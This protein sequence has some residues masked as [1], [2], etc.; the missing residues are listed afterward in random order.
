MPV[1]DVELH[2]PGKN[3]RRDYDPLVQPN[4]VTNEA[5]NLLDIEIKFPIRIIYYRTPNDASIC[6]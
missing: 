6:W 5:V 1:D 4:D 2:K 3:Y